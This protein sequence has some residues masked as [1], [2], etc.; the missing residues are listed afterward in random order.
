M[1]FFFLYLGTCFLCPL[2]CF[3]DD[4][5]CLLWIFGHSY[6][7]WGRKRASAHPACRQLGF[8]PSDVQVRWLGVRGLRWPRFLSE[9][10]FFVG[11]DRALD[12]VAIH[13]GGNDLGSRTSRE[14]LRDIKVDCLRLWTSYPGIIIV[15]SDIVA[16]RVWHHALRLNS[17]TRLMMRMM[18]MVSVP[19]AALIIMTR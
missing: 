18:M 2:V 3:S 15:W 14:L 8:S 6:V 17:S 12:I 9:F 5:P 11:L 10:Q 1:W 4:V 19:I 13:A 16:R 7:Y